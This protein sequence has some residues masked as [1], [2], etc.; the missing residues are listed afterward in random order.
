MVLVNIIS[1]NYIDEN[2]TNPSILVDKTK[3]AE[4]SS[5]DDEEIKIDDLIELMQKTVAS[6]M[7]L[8]SPIDDQ[9][10]QVSRED[11]QKYKL[12]KE[13]VV[14]EAKVANLK[15]LPSYP[16][17]QQLTELLLNSLKP[18]FNNLIKAHNFSSL[19]PTELKDLLRKFEA[20]NGTLALTKKVDKLEGLKLEIQV[21]LVALHVQVSS[22]GSQLAK[23]KVLDA[24]STILGKVVVAMDRFA[25]DISLESQKAG[26]TSVL[27]AC[28]AGPHPAEGEKNTNQST[29]TQLF[30]IRHVKD[31]AAANLI[32]KPTTKPTIT[33]PTT[34][35]IIKTTFVIIPTITP[36]F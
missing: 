12:E 27:L 31:V 34:T 16:N 24:I 5:N 18:E 28:Q 9:P 19:I 3:S 30:Q 13:K 25:H 29:I 15:A 2:W 22:I 10:I 21:D 8:E 7:E 14:V 33:E 23:L 11:S 1:G 17:V 35:Q 36:P 20:I 6:S 32:N 26:D 4:D